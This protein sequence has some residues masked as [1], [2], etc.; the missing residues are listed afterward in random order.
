MQCMGFLNATSLAREAAAYGAAG[1]RPQVVWA[2]GMLASTAV[3]VAVDLM[4]NWTGGVHAPIYLEYD[5]N[6]NELKRPSRAEYWPREC[7]HYPASEVGE[8]RFKPV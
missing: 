6:T 2:N 1:V 8:P 3:S 7:I 5:G 4:T